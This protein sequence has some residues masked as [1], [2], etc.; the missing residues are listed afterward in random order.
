LVCRL[1]ALHFTCWEALLLNR[2][3]RETISGEHG[4]DG[5]G[6]Y[7]PSSEIAVAL[8][9]RWINLS[10]TGIMEL[11]ISRK[12]DLM[13]ISVKYG[14]F[15]SYVD[16]VQASREKYVPRAVLVDLE[17]GTMDTIKAGAFGDLFRPDNFVFGNSG[18]GNNWAK[19]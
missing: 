18:A 4:L 8:L 7:V 9:D 3:S 12:N 17:P 16:A 10:W 2:V 14:L 11:P 19:G 5:S 15:F 6:A 1:V 13:S